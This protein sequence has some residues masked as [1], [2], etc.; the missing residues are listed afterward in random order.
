MDDGVLL[1]RQ[2]TFYVKEGHS[3]IAWRLVS[4]AARACLDLGFHRLSSSPHSR[5]A[6]Q[7]SA[8]FWYIYIWDKGLAMTCGRTPVIH[9]Y[10]VTT[11]HP[12]P[13]GLRHDVASRLV[14]RCRRLGAA[15]MDR[16]HGAFVDLAIVTGEIQQTLFSASARHASQRARIQH[17]RG[18]AS[19]LAEI[20]ESVRPVRIADGCFVAHCR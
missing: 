10:D 15:D 14:H 17:A 2:G 7:Q 3:T 9:H 6:S 5:L 8:V 19:R 4:A 16:I 20:Q 18:F 12:I 1:T 13:R 11:T